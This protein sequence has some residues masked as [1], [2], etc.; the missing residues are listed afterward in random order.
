MGPSG[1]DAWRCVQPPAPVRYDGVVRTSP[2]RVRSTCCVPRVTESR[3]ASEPSNYLDLR[4]IISLTTV[5]FD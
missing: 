2:L 4:L 5:L 3:R 1:L